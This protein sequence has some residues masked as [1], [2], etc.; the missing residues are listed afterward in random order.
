MKDPAIRAR[1]QKEM[2]TP[3]DDWENL[4]MAAGPEKVLLIGFKSDA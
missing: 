2:T 3:S 1:L 4:L